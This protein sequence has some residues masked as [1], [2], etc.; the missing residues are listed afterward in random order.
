MAQNPDIYASIKAIALD[1]DGVM[2]DGS[3]QLLADGD[4]LRT[5]DAKDSFAV[6]VA[7]QKGLTV[8]FI[9]GGQTE[10]LERRCRHLGCRPEN[11]YLGTRG[12]LAAF[13]DFCEKNG[14]EASEV[15]YFGDDIPDTQV[16]AAAGIGVAPADAALE[17]KEAAD[18][19]S[20]YP[21]GHWCVR[22]EIEKLL[23][24]QG[25]W[26]FDPDKYDQIF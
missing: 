1:I 7:A 3:L 19:V 12:K 15:M 4:I 26:Y 16:L 17:A 22:T 23:R 25:K 13:R 24:A 21:G 5:M 18:I 9:S 2:T 20:E 6:R 14:L 8:A 10:A 11:L